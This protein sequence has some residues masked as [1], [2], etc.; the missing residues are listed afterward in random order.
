MRR[1]VSREQPKFE[2][3]MDF[4]KS[5]IMSDPLSMVVKMR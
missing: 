3:K 5:T 2:V 1:K 4:L